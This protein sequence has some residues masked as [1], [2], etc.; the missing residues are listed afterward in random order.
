VKAPQNDFTNAMEAALLIAQAVWDKSLSDSEW[1]KLADATFKLNSKKKE[2]HPPY[3][4]DIVASLK[5][6]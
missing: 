2:S 3:D 1:E 6:T 5:N 4:A